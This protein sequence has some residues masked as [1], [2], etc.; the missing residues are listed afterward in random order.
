MRQ[1]AETALAFARSSRMRDLLEPGWTSR[2]R[3]VNGL[4]LHM[5]EAG[6]ADGPP[7]FLLHGFPEFWWAWRRQITPLADAG[8]R[9]IVPDMRGYNLSDAPGDVSAYEIHILAADIAALADAYDARRFRLVGHDWGGLVAWQVAASY[10]GRIERMVVMNAPHPDTWIKQ[11]LKHP[12]Q[13]LRSTYMAFFQLPGVPE[14]TL[15]AFD[16]AGL[17]A[18]V[19]RTARP[20]AL[21]PGEIE[22]Y[23]EAWTRP[24]R[25]TAML[26]YYRALRERQAGAPQ[27]IAP[28]TLIL[29]G[30]QDSFLEMHEAEADLAMCADGRLVTVDEATHW[31]HLE[32]PERVNR[33]LIAFLSDA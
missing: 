24:G 20:D 14:A 13:A 1:R 4:A 29:W 9:V 22:R 21:R 12:T 27:R 8:Y 30:R 5:I 16:A 3:E 23:V 19:E 10:P 33:E 25:F 6:P 7:L 18:M 15:T 26:N 17:R 31:L 32:E 11:A 28:R 2:T